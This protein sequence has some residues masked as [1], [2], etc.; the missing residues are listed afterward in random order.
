MPKLIKYKKKRDFSVT[1]EPKGG[2]PRQSAAK[3]IFVIQKHDA[4]HLHYDLRLEMDGVLKS[5]AIPK[6]PSLNHLDKRLAVQTE[7]HPLEYQH[8]EGIIPAGEY[9][10]GTVII[11]DNGTYASIKDSALIKDYENGHIEIQL[12][13]K[14][15]KG[16]F[17]L[18]RFINGDKPQWLFIKL[19]D[20]YEDSDKD[21]TKKDKSVVSGKTIKQ[22]A[23]E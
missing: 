10:G 19:K 23:A 3:L 9:G 20:K 6:G 16:G 22:V 11:W 15:L 8:F 13:G 14:K 1:P 18:Q 5:W 17:L 12:K 7:D 2:K 4:S 21:I